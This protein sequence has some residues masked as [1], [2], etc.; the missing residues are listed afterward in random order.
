MLLFN[1]YSPFVGLF[2]AGKWGITYLTN[3]TA[4]VY[5]G[6]VGKP[7]ALFNWGVEQTK[8]DKILMPKLV[9]NFG[10]VYIYNYYVNASK[11][12]A[13]QKFNEVGIPCPP[14][15][16]K[17]EECRKYETVLVRKDKMRSGR[18]IERIRGDDAAL[19]VQN[20][21]LFIVPLLDILVEY[22]IFVF[23]ENILGWQFRYENQPI[24]LPCPIELHELALQAVKALSL[25]FG[26]VDIALLQD[27]NPVVFEVNTRP[28]LHRNNTIT[29]LLHQ[30]IE[31]L[32]T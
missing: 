28:G 9:E 19:L 26:A 32:L 1:K 27:G 23:N 20:S 18:G 22:R 21:D 15:L 31:A 24:I 16:T 13:F 30:R 17:A 3:D 10:M 6:S 29:S 2:N 12:E 11:V 25:D 14:L 5:T 8:I 7:K 4:V